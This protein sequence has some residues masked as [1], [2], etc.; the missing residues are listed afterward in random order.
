M[1]D[2]SFFTRFIQLAGEFWT[3]EDNADNRRSTMVLV[4]LTVAQIT[5]AVLITEWS[6][7]L[8][9]ALEQRSMSGLVTQIGFIV[10]IFFANIIITVNH[11]KIKR[12]LQI[13]WR[14]WLT[15][16]VVAR[17]MHQGRHYLITHLEEGE[18]DNPDG[19]IAEDIRVATETA[20]ELCHSLLFSVLLL[21]SFTQ[22]L[23]TLSGVV[24]LDIGFINMPIH[25]YLVWLALIYAVTASFLGWLI[26][27]PLTSATDAKQTSEANFRFS[28]VTSQEHSL[29]IAMI[30]GESHERKRFH[31]LFAD[32]GEAWQQQTKAWEHILMFSSGYSIL[33][34]AFPI[35]VSAPRFILGSITLGALMQ[36]AQSFQQMAS[37]LSWPVDNMARI[38]EWRASV[39]RILGL[40]ESLD[41]LEQEIIRP[42]PNHIKLEKN[43]KSILNF[44][45]VCI[46]KLN[47]Q[48]IISCVNEEI[49]AGQHVLITGN[50][51]TGSKLFKAITGLWPWGKGR[52]ALPDGNTL[53]FMP[54]RPYLPTGTLRSAICYPAADDAFSQEAMETALKLADL[55]D[56]ITQLDSS[57]TWEKL[58]SRETQQRLGLARLLLNRPKWVFLQEAF[59]SLDNDSEMDVLRLICRE[60]PDATLLTITN[61]PRASAFHSH[62][63]HLT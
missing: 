59:D 62:T 14:T 35:L 1:N 45:Q 16:R 54:P 63:L 41:R 50:F 61:L 37:A 58:F 51:F 6:A 28:L 13:G 42:D 5:I 27:R 60:L 19:R 44:D 17:W 20:I 30:H 3:A 31:D 53:F 57:D 7:A 36:S 26:G 4:A 22:I 8:F 29:S 24:T 11:L 25:G 43:D 52:I 33:S 39:E 2:S 38:F 55:D 10:L 32:I 12:S 48:E 18:H 56:L 47:G 15:E 49:R 34:M 46:L 9:N 21:F 40:L 23:W